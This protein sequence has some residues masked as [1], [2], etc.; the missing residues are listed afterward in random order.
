[1]AI[2]W[3]HVDVLDDLVVV[4]PVFESVYHQVL[5]YIQHPGH[6]EIAMVIGPT[7]C[8]KSTLF[9]ILRSDTGQHVDEPSGGKYHEPPILVE[10]AAPKRQGFPWRQLYTDILY[11]LGEF[12]IDKKVSVARDA[13]EDAIQTRASASRVTLEE[14]GRIVEV[15]LVDRSPAGLI[16]DEGQ[17]LGASP[18]YRVLRN[19]LEVIK[20]HRNRMPT[21]PIIIGGTY[22]AQQMLATNA[23]LARRIRIIHYRPYGTTKQDRV[24]FG[25]IVHLFLDRLCVS[26]GTGMPEKHLDFIYKY[27]AG[28][29]GIWS[30]WL[31]R[32]ILHAVGRSGRV[33]TAQDLEATRHTDWEVQAIYREINE[34]HH[35]YAGNHDLDR[36]IFGQGEGE[37]SRGRSK[38]GRARPGVRAPGRDLTGDGRNGA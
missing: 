7:G 16:I 3:G 21:V 27:S 18:T 26:V 19:Q 8:G 23:Q 34:F 17:H 22:Q 36:V 10:A 11:Q 12:A 1:M 5:S 9:S 30:A 6:G 25:E 15:A 38:R 13:R 32:A 14:L 33:L 20:D 4:H 35:F 31:R 29:V 2:E 28:C 24:Q 37:P